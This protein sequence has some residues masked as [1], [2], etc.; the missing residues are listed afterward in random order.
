MRIFYSAGLSPDRLWDPAG[1]L[2]DRRRSVF[3]VV[4]GNQSMNPTIHLRVVPMLAAPALVCVLRDV[5]LGHKD[6]EA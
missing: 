5:V 1:L 3:D 6:G 2:T 4:K